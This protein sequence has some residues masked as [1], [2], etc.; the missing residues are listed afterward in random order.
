MVLLT[1]GLGFEGHLGL[2]S[3]HPSTDSKSK[4]KG[5][6]IINGR[7]RLEGPTLIQIV[8]QGELGLGYERQKPYI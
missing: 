8:A 5:L 6:I 4:G 7:A 1:L 2:G 3:A